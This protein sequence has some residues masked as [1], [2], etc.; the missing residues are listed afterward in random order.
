[1]KLVTHPTLDVTKS[2]RP[3][4][5]DFLFLY[6]PNKIGIFIPLRLLSVRPLSARILA[7]LQFA[8]ERLSLRLAE[9][10]GRGPEVRREA[11]ARTIGGVT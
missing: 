1:M 4:P 8:L 11:A 10:V 7:V 5:F 9:L 2:H 6:R 3:V